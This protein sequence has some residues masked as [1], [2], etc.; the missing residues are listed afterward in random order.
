MLSGNRALSH[1]P[2]PALPRRGRVCS[3]DTPDEREPSFGKRERR[4]PRPLLVHET[5]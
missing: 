5:K 3:H 1:K 4:S 2:G